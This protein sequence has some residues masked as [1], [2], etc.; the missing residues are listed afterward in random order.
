MKKILKWLAIAVGST[1]GILLAIGMLMPDKPVSKQE[2]QPS[3]TLPAS[4]TAPPPKSVESVQKA[5]YAPDQCLDG[6]CIGM[7][8]GEIAAIDWRK[9]EVLKESDMNNQQRE[10]LEL[11]QKADA[12]LC[13]SRQAAWGGKAQDVCKLLARSAINRT[14]YGFRIHQVPVVLEF[15]SKQ[16]LPVCEFYQKYDRIE[17]TRSLS[18]ESGSTQVK[19]R[20]DALGLFKIFEISKGYTNQNAETNASIKSKLLEKHPYVV[21]PTLNPWGEPE[22]NGGLTGVA[23]WGGTVSIRQ[24]NGNAPGISMTAKLAEF[25]QSNLAACKQAKPVSV[26]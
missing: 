6:V 4:A 23:D 14:N 22:A 10:F 24:N 12:D 3:G 19:F 15:F 20:F 25:D 2:A 26:Q 11:D 18:T 16:T 8:A 17:V 5:S 9:K 13:A 1:L 7:T 21:K